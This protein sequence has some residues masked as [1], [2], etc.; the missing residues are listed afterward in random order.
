ML[1]FGFFR[2]PFGL[3][4]RSAKNHPEEDRE[5]VL[6]EEVQPHRDSKSQ[7]GMKACHEHIADPE[8]HMREGKD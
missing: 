4:S 2:R 8:K 5:Q 6:S 1:I 3:L 7:K